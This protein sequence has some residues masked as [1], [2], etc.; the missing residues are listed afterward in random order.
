MNNI[1]QKQTFTKHLHRNRNRIALDSEDIENAPVALVWI[2]F[3]FSKNWEKL[4]SIH[5]T[6][7][8]IIFKRVSDNQTANHAKNSVSFYSVFIIWQFLIVPLITLLLQADHPSI[9]EP[10]SKTERYNEHHCN[11][12]WIVSLGGEKKGYWLKKRV[13]MYVHKHAWIG[14]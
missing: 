9:G 7:I 2:Q 12:R 13:D 10:R 8:S 1:I 6:M 4:I 11:E 3:Y 5:C 14:V